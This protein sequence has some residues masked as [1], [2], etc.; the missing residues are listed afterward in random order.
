MLS[1]GRFRVLAGLTALFAYVQIVL[2][3]LV[4]VSGS[5]LGCPDWPTCY[6]RPYPPADLHAVIEYSHRTVGAFTGL[7]IIATLLAAF[8]IYRG[9]RSP[10]TWMAVATLAAVVAEGLLGWRVVASLLNP[11]LVQIHLAIGLL[12]LGL[13]LSQALLAVPPVAPRPAASLG[14]LG[15]AAT[16]LTFLMLLTG[17]S[18]VASGAD[19]VCKSWPLCGGGFALDLSNPAFFGVSHRLVV[20]AVS[21]LLVYW[22]VLV[23]RRQASRPGAAL[24]AG[25]TL[26]ALTAQVAVGA[27]AAVTNEVAAVQGLHVALAAAVWAGVVSLTLLLLRPVAATLDVAPALAFEGRPA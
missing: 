19:K 6:G 2:G 3:G 11:S 10:V 13:L 21:L 26:L 7:L 25:L 16:A 15:G 18:V 20:L 8:W 9:R 23:L 14:L 17:S 22:L 4:R 5:G 1:P 27:A 12:V 24:V